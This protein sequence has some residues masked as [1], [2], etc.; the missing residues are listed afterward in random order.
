[1]FEAYDISEHLLSWPIV[2]FPSK[3]TYPRKENLKRKSVSKRRYKSLE[4]FH[5]AWHL[6]VDR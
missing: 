4:E 1:M 5:T 6:A 2:T 3:Y